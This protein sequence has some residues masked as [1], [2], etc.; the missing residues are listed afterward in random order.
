LKKRRKDIVEY[1]DTL[2]AIT[3][4]SYPGNPQNNTIMYI[5]KKFE[6]LI[7]QLSSVSGCLVFLENGIAV[8][9]TI[10]ERNHFN[11]SDIP[12][13]DYARAAEV[14]WK[15]KQ[16]GLDAL[17]YRKAQDATIGE[18][19]NIARDVVIEPGAFIDHEVNIGAGTRILA[20][21]TIR[22][23]TIIGKNCLI[24]ERAIVGD[25]GFTMAP[26]ENGYP[27]RLH[28]LAGVELADEVEVGSGATVCRGQSRNT[29]IGK[30]TKIDNL[31][32]L[33]HDVSLGERVTI[34]AGVRLG[35]FVEIGDRSYLGMGAV[36]KQL[37]SVGSDTIVGMG[38][39]VTASLPDGVRAWGIPARIQ[40][41]SHR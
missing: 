12:V 19:C 18:K 25:E 30:W 35:G 15:R 26:D 10:L 36:V 9:D 24:K 7:S 8:P 31:S 11:H 32:Y 23:G 16:A 1:T 6:Y 21:A 39:V 17:T 38:A 20:G 37:L 4:V 29:F 40:P 5:G 2:K 33:A 22:H 34:T 13:R 3:G 41:T 27:F 14:L 28:C